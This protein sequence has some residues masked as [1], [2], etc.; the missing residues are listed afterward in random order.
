MR[1]SAYKDSSAT[2]GCL[3][4]IG[5]F[6]L[7]PFFAAIEG[8]VLSWCWFWFLS[9]TFGIRPIGTWEAIGIALLFGMLTRRESKSD[10]KDSSVW[11]VALAQ[12]VGTLAVWPI[13]WMIYHWGMGR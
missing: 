9:S 5:I 4:V 11:A 13:G 6:A 1:R 8:W 12:T 10:T 2:E 7:L 3:T